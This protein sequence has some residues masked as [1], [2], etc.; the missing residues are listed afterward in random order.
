MSAARSRP[1][2]LRW[3]APRDS[4]T[5]VVTTSCDLHLHSKASAAN[6][7]WYSRDFGC[8]ES[9]AEP[10]KQYELCKT[11]GMSLVTLTDHDTIAGGLE[12][13]DR[14]DFFLS[15][16]VSTTFPEDGSQIHVLAWNI[17]TAQHDRLQAARGS[18]YDLVEVLHRERI[19]HACAHPLF[20]P[21]WRLSPETLEKILV[22]FPVL[23]GI[24]GLTDR[25][26][27]RD[28]L[29]LLAGV[30]RD[31]LGRL[32]RRHGLPEPLTRHALVAGSDD[33]SHRGCAS[34]FTE[35]A[36][37]GLGAAEFLEIAV[38]GGAAL[39]GQQA[40]LDAMC[41]NASRVTYGFLSARTQERPAYRDPFVDLIDV[42]AG[43]PAGSGGGG[44]PD[45]V[46][47]SLLAG[48]ARKM[49]TLGPSL[50]LDCLERSD[51]KIA[52]T[53]RAVHDGLLAHACDE[54]IDGVGDLDIYRALGG[55]RDLAAAGATAVPFLLAADHF[56]KQRRQA[57]DVLSRWT[58]TSVALP[59]SRLAIF[60]DSLE[61][62]DGVTTSLGR[63][64]REA[65]AGGREVRVPY[66][67]KPPR[68]AIEGVHVPLE[69]AA[70]HTTGLYAGMQFHVP[71]LLGTVDWM[72]RQE[73]THVELATP[74][75]MGIF[76]LIAARLHRLPVTASYHTE[77]PELLRHLS[78]SPVLHSA[79]SKLAA[80]FYAAVDKVFAFS[81]Q[82]RQRLID[83][84][85]PAGRITLA[86]VAID[87]CE[88]SP[89]HACAKVYPE[90][91]VPANGAP[92]VLTVGRL[93]REKNVPLIIEAVGRLQH[94]PVPP[95]LVIA[96]D[97]P[98]RGAIAAACANKPYVVMVGLQQG[99]RLKRLY[100]TAS[101][102]VFASRI[103]TLGLVTMEAMSSG[104]P[105]VVPRDAAIAELVEH[106]ASGYCYEFGV[107]GLTSALGDV[108]ASSTRRAALAANARQAMVD[109]WAAARSV[110]SWP[111]LAGRSD[112][113]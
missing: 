8:P 53:I 39:R 13:I 57:T 99:D 60:S 44:M 12:L 109:R 1:G 76:G 105:V 101:A 103:D 56:A 50:D 11:R 61:Q 111:T 104:V 77:L 6:A 18:V 110:P 107:D 28:L 102:F 58:A 26:V 97:G 55:L 85:V 10:R 25:R 66:C 19:A 67:G 24:N 79:A 80:W 38:A 63:F 59:A 51:A 89:D 108:L 15:E 83:L 98:E 70:T 2:E 100:A 40:D 71:S 21:N 20:S 30:D 73:I 34:C 35:V 22:L 64:V 49:T 106:G 33:H 3:Y 87:P 65:R 75:P 42:V 36:R 94:L 47:L 78:A 23:E 54:I 93:S 72:W 74:G 69:C 86:P 81:E 5:V 84:G 29:E 41:L 43:R 27:E 91:G 95:V 31:V 52:S 92:I 32:A 82:S 46:V 37:G 68:D 7:E 17:T 4:Q 88:F 113:A 9:Y 62:V 90:L 112:L 45:Q 14:P 96:G 16:E 48:A